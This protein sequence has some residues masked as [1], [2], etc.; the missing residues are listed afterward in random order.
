MWKISSGSG[1]AG[2]ST[3]PTETK[4]ID[5]AAARGITG[6]ST[7][8]RTTPQHVQSGQPGKHA[9]PRCSVGHCSLQERSPTNQQKPVAWPKN[10]ANVTVTRIF[11]TS[12]FLPC[13]ASPGYE[14]LVPHRWPKLTDL[15]RPVD[16]VVVGTNRDI[17]W[18]IDGH[19]RFEQ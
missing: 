2:A 6:R 8:P 12:G 18:M 19:R 3:V 16:V 14:Q 13:S 5:G 4:L 7:T 11:T 17:Q 15:V 1:D 9:P 10:R